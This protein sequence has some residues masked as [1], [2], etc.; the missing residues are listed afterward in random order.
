[1]LNFAYPLLLLLLPA[2]WLV[3]WLVPAIVLKRSSVRVPFL[4]RLPNVDSSDRPAGNKAWL[5][6][7]VKGIIWTLVIFALARPQW[8]GAP[9]ERIEPTRDL[10]LLVDLS[11]SMNQDDF[12]GADG[13][14]TTRLSALKQVIKDFLKDRE[15][16]R[17]GLVVF[18]NSPFVQIPFTDDLELI[19]QLVDETDVGMAG[20]RT[21]LG[22]AIGL[23]IK[24]FE[25]SDAP[26]KTIIALT[27]GN[28]NASSVPATQAARVAANQQITI[29]TI[30]MGDPKTV[31]EE[32]LDM[33]SLQQVS[34]STGGQ[35]FLAMNRSELVSAYSAIDQIETQELTKIGYRPRTDLY[36]WPL[37]A[38]LLL[39]L[40]RA[41]VELRGQPAVRPP[42]AQSVQLRVN[43]RTFELETVH[44]EA[45]SDQ[46]EVNA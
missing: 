37:A 39:S 13:Q 41:A 43:S 12:Q 3:H 36:F 15:S 45:S 40:G 16:D 27:D 9:I 34:E 14:S 38:A 44:A 17:V 31:G 24:L 10:L 4:S 22:D 33:E 19:D 32:E 35:T 8:V 1:M 29:H 25:H 42:D 6:T 11:G 18:G 20:P 30:A 46:H 23:G 5:A 2:P 28:D 7:L 26:E 21:A